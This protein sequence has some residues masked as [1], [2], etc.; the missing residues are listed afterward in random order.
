MIYNYQ[1]GTDRFM[2][3][4]EKDEP[5]S[6]FATGGDRAGEIDLIWEP[7]KYTAS[8]IIQQKCGRESN[9]WKVVDI[10]TRSSYT[11]AG[12]KSGKVYMFR[13]APMKNKANKTWSLQVKIKAP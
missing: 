10:V 1:T 6:L 13:V 2:K 7:V 11:A 9:N 8:Y 5:L 3:L 12:L 4:P